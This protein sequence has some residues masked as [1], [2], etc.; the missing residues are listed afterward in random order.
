MIAYGSDASRDGSRGQAFAISERIGPDRSHG[1]A[2][3]G[4]RNDNRTGRFIRVVGD[5]DRGA[6]VFVGELAKG[7]CGQRQRGQKE[8]PSDEE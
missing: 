8:R 7:R 1:F 3:D 4:C 6:V 5:G 2:A